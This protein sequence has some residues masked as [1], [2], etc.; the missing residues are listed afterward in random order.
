M[1][2]RRHP[3]RVTIKIPINLTQFGSDIVKVKVGCTIFSEAITNGTGAANQYMRKEQE[4]PMSGGKVTETV[5]LVFSFTQLNNPVGKTATVNCDLTGWSTVDQAWT[6]FG[7]NRAN[8]SFRSST[9]L[10]GSIG[11]PFTW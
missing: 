11:N 1:P 2:P 10:S 8:P 9:E 4:V 3:L 6:S 7:P 5:S